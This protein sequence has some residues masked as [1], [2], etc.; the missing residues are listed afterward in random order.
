MG[1]AIAN[2]ESK[3][4]CAIHYNRQNAWKSKSVSEMRSSRYSSVL[5]SGLPRQDHAVFASDSVPLP[6]LPP[7]FF[8]P[9]VLAALNLV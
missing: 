7:P 4:C 3:V 6:N 5:L 9:A 2:R 1:V 8:S